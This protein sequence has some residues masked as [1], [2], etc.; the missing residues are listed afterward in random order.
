VP[1]LTDLDVGWV[2][3]VDRAAVRDPVQQ[4]EPAR[5]LIWKR[6]TSDEGDSM[7]PEEKAALE[8]AQADVAALTEKL[9]KADE[10]NA[11]L[12]AKVTEL[13]KAAEPAKKEEP[14][15]KADLPPAVRAALEKAEADAAALAERLEKSENEAKAER[16]IAKAERET[17][18]TREFV[19]K[20][21]GYKA[22]VV[23]AEDF[24]PVLKACA[25]KLTKDEY[26]AI[27][28]VLKAADEQIVAGDLFKE[29]GRGREA[30]APDGAYA[31]ATQKAE[32]LRKSDP[33][34]SLAKARELVFKA[35]TDLQA[36]YL[37]EQ[38]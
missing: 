14:I 4:S 13:E 23:K 8:K 31:E 33:K 21:E 36:R 28:Q 18:L 30:A 37:A 6:Q 27:E 34:L 19:T 24:G 10:T 2:S 29:Q 20:A 22:L 9:T 3:L 12:A 26:A 5:F 1:T 15:D 17:R 35:D 32:E 16:D 38:R 7:T 11:A 25:E